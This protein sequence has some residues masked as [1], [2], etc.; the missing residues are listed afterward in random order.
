MQ[1]ILVY[2][3]VNL[4]VCYIFNIS[5]YEYLEKFPYLNSEFKM[6]DEMCFNR[7]L[8]PNYGR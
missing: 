2:F 5:K 8:S 1:G 4:K 3:K 6:Q 7:G